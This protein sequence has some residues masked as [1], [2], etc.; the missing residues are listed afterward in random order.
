[1]RSSA[2]FAFSAI[3]PLPPYC[4][5]R[6][7]PLV[8]Q[9]LEREPHHPQPLR[10]GHHVRPHLLDGPP[11]RRRQLVGH[12]VRV[13]QL[14]EVCLLKLRGEVRGE[15]G[16]SRDAFGVR[17]PSSL[18]KSQEH[19]T[20]G[21]RTTGFG[22]PCNND[23]EEAVQSKASSRRPFQLGPLFQS[24]FFL[25]FEEGDLITPSF[26][27]KCLASLRRSDRFKGFPVSG[28]LRVIPGALFSL[29]PSPLLGK[30][31]FQT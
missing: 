23:L 10:P 15:P 31:C 22:S 11:A 13:A 17:C 27:T 29:H 6:R 16:R 12:S 5:P 1:M 25:L 8:V 28:C 4:S 18:P 20:L 21:R 30:A 14:L 24:G 3:I 2:N 7:G 19:R 26:F 9:P